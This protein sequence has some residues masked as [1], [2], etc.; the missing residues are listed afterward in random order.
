METQR[1][2]LGDHD[3]YELFRHA[4]LNHDEDAWAESSSRYRPLL[5]A[6]AVY[7]SARTTI[8]EHCDDIADQALA[9]AWKAISPA[10]F[11]QFQ[12]LAGLLAYLRTCVT[13]VV[14]DYARTQRAIERAIHK[15]DVSPVATPEQVVLEKMGRTELWRLV[16][17]IVESEQERTILLESFLLDLPPRT[18]LVRHP[19]LFADIA[20]LYNAKRNLLGRLQRNRELQ[21]L[22]EEWLST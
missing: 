2:G 21:Q 1:A 5:I 19:D 22:R 9:R 4:I 13:A 20:A 8:I 6:W 18:I 7:C 16:N 11:A 15:L 17:T 12:S 14:I 10:R 3:G